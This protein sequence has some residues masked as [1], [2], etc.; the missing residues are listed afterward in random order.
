[1]ALAVAAGGLF[2]NVGRFFAV[3]ETELSH[4]AA[5]RVLLRLDGLEGRE[6]VPLWKSFEFHS[7]ATDAV[8]E[9]FLVGPA[10]AHVW[11][12]RL[13]RMAFPEAE[14]RVGE[15]TDAA[16]AALLASKS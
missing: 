4:T 13:G 16:L 1:M 14:L 6:L 12:Q 2:D 8:E 9:A 7:H 10:A 5:R 11:L 15:D 3:L